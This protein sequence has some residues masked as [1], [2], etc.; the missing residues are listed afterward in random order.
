MIPWREEAAEPK[1]VPARPSSPSLGI[2]CYCSS[3]PGPEPGEPPAPGPVRTFGSGPGHAPAP[4]GCPGGFP[5][6][7]GSRVRSSWQERPGG[8]KTRSPPPTPLPRGK[9]KAPGPVGLHP[10]RRGTSSSQRSPSATGSQRTNSVHAAPPRPPRATASSGESRPQPPTPPAFTWSRPAVVLK[11]LDGSAHIIGSTAPGS[12]P[13]PPSGIRRVPAVV[14]AEHM[15]PP[16]AEEGGDVGERPRFGLRM[17][18]TPKGPQMD[19]PLPPGGSGPGVTGGSREGPVRDFRR[20]RGSQVSSPRGI[21]AAGARTGFPPRFR[22][23]RLVTRLAD[24]RAA[25]LP[26]PPPLPWRRGSSCG[27]PPPLRRTLPLLPSRCGRQ[28][29]SRYTCSSLRGPRRPPVSFSIRR[30]ARMARSECP[31]I[32]QE[33]VRGSPTRSDPKQ[34]VPPDRC[35]GTLESEVSGGHVARPRGRRGFHPS[36]PRSTPPPAV[37]E[38][39]RRAGR[40]SGGPASRGSHA[41]SPRRSSLTVANLPGSRDHV[42]TPG[43]S[44]PD[45]PRGRSPPPPST[46]A[47]RLQPAPP[48]TGVHIHAGALHHPPLLR[49]FGHTSSS[50]PPEQSLPPRRAGASRRRRAMR[51][52]GLPRVDQRDADA[53]TPFSRV[54]SASA[55]SRTRDPARWGVPGP[56]RRRHGGPPSGL[57]LTGAWLAYSPARRAA[58]RTMTK[59]RASARKTPS[60]SV[61]WTSSVPSPPKPPL[62][63]PA[64]DPGGRDESSGRCPYEAGT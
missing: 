17:Y 57:H 25:P 59:S 63:D 28:S 45:D 43:G 60:S 7:S 20:R 19:G 31:P 40:S 42:V 32:V 55:S 2:K 39:G 61:M 6:P 26:V 54:A 62:S 12:G 30:M 5:A 52:A 29:A 24:P 27:H 35:H 16:L 15:Y 4:P 22:A 11:L 56:P 38:A 1:G 37:C 46:P 33:V 58:T 21:E 50:P 36:A 51:S 10:R 64:P 48:T 47:S 14:E 49:S 41:R 18:S 13:P 8:G 53:S 34:K 9:P 44:P 3:H 23:G